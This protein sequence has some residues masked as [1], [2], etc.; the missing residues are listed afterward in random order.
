MQ[1]SRLSWARWSLTRAM[2]R[3]E[4]TDR[5]ILLLQVELDSQLL[6]SKELQQ[7]RHL[8]EHRMAELAE[9]RQFR[10]NPLLLPP[11]PP[12]PSLEDL[13]GR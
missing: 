5:R 6:R 12:S 7:H 8:L 9:I 1:R 4:R 13:L 10:E 3:A 11:V 2:R